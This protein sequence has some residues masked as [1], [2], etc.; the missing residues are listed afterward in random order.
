MFTTTVFRRFSELK[1]KSALTSFRESLCISTARNIRAERPSTQR[2]SPRHPRT[3]R[4]DFLCD[5]ETSGEMRCED[6]G[7]RS[8]ISRCTAILRF[9]TRSDCSSARRCS[10]CSIILTLRRPREISKARS[11]SI[12]NSD[13]R[14]KRWGNTWEASMWAAAVLTG[15]TRSAVLVPFN[16]L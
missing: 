8:G 3:R 10:T 13:Y 6:S 14:P 2:H 16:S 12:R 5:K 7:Q 15:C 11:P 1:R 4:R 9:V